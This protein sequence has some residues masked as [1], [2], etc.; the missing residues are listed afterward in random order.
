MTK[1]ILIIGGGISGLAALHFLKEKYK[2]SP[3]VR[4]QLLEKSPRTG[5]TMQTLREGPY[6]F[7]CG[8][9]GFLGSKSE[10]LELIEALGL[11]DEL[12][13]AQPVS[14][15]RYICVKNRLHALSPSLPALLGFAPLSPWDKLRLPAEIFVPKGTTADESVYEFVCRRFGRKC[16]EYLADPLVTGIFAADARQLSLRAAFPQIYNMEQTHGSL[17]RAMFTRKRVRSGKRRDIL[18]SLRNGMGQLTETLTALYHSDIKTNVEAYS[19]AKSGEGYI[20]QSSETKHFAD[21]LF[22]CTP[23]FAAAQLLHE[24]NPAL[25]GALAAIQYAPIAV[26]GLAFARATAA[27]LPPGFGY[28]VPSSENNATLGTIFSSNVYAQRS[29]ADTI[30]V[31]VLQGGARHPEITRH[32]P[33]QIVQLARAEIKRTCRIETAP[34]K[35]FSKIW[36]Q[37]IPQYNLQYPAIIEKIDQELSAMSNLFLLANYRNGVAVNDCISNAKLAAQNLGQAIRN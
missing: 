6:Q 22:V 3:D 18:Y 7:E 14:A 21:T 10:T 23:A 34:L 33:A 29:S 24:L 28:L 25:A 19:V 27:A 15:N 5:G 30:L 4:I 17:I 1:Q 8:P 35:I 37:G 31:Q 13:Q 32:S 11:K 26:T 9:N 2:S 20:V 12:I 36:T 16:A